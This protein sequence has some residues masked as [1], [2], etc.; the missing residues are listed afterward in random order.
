MT[1]HTYGISSGEKNSTV[2]AARFG[3][4]SLLLRVAAGFSKAVVL[5]GAMYG[6]ESSSTF[7]RFRTFGRPSPSTSMTVPRRLVPKRLAGPNSSGMGRCSS[8]RVVERSV[9]RLDSKLDRAVPR[10]RLE[11]EA[12]L[13]VDPRRPPEAV[14]ARDRIGEATA[15]ATAPTWPAEVTVERSGSN[16]RR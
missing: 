1:R 11:T 10:L 5:Y 13:R 7:T 8:S 15:V 16:L 4:K 6:R 3:Q 9:A 12:R 2:C 14:A